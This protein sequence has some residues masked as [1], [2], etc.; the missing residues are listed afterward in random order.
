MSE[1]AI[2]IDEMD[3]KG[4]SND[5]LS[6]PAKSGKQIVSWQFKYKKYQT[7]ATAMGDKG[8]AVPFVIHARNWRLD[9]DLSVKTDKEWNDALMSSDR[10]GV[11]FW[12]LDDV[13]KNSKIIDRAQTLRKLM[14]MSV[15]Q[16]RGMLNKEEFGDA[17]LP[18]NCSDKMQLVMA[19]IDKS[20]L[21]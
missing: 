9:L 4:K 3:K 2:K 1:Q 15:M 17:G 12:L 6:T 7:I 20:V 21:K 19:I 5:A 13:D 14:D 18:T 8:V 10:K 16:L 11:D